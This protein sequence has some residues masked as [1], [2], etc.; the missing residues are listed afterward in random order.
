MQVS[1]VSSRACLPS[2]S[3]KTSPRNQRITLVSFSWSCLAFKAYS[4]YTSSVRWTCTKS[5]RSCVPSTPVCA[6]SA[7][8]VARNSW[9]PMSSPTTLSLMPVYACVRLRPFLLSSKVLVPVVSS[10]EKHQPN[11][12]FISDKVIENGV[13]LLCCH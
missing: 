9:P 8:S 13:M 6:T 4:S 7:P 11:A 12:K 1:S 10:L 5:F 2:S 3:R